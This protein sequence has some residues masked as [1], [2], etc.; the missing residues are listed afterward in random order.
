MLH[1]VEEP[2]VDLGDAVNGLVVDAALE[3]LI[4]AEDALGVLHIHVVHDLVVAQLLEGLWVRV[5][6]PSSMEET[7]F[8]IAASKLL[9]M[10]MTSPVAIIWVP[11]D[12][13]A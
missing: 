2:P 11:R 7:A 4:D 1:L 10:L 3:G 13:S 9:P 8:I 5:S 12:L 6:M